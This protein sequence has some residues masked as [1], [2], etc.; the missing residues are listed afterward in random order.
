M[1]GN[2]YRITDFFGGFNMTE[3]QWVAGTILAKGKDDKYLFLVED[4]EGKFLLPWTEICDG[5]TSL[6]C[7]IKE[8][9]D[10]LNVEASQLSLYDLSNAII[11]GHRVPLFVFMLEDKK[12]SAQQIVRRKEKQYSWEP[13]SSL[14][15]TLGEVEISGVPNFNK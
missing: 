7:I 15:E 12:I 6:A 1:K 11:Q 4:K 10:I 9:K 8:L 2:E 5:K 13:S 14:I 3:E